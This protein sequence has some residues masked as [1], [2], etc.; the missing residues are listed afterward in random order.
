LFLNKT[1]RFLPITLEASQ[2]GLSSTLSRPT[3][4][5]DQKLAPTTTPTAGTSVGAVTI[6]LSTAS[7]WLS[8]RSHIS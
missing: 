6:D 5:Y 7:Y 1:S 4:F 3:N 2:T 8:T